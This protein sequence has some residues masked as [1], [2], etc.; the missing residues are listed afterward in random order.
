M[1]NDELLDL[2]NEK[3]EVIG[4]VLRS[5]AM[6]DPAK[7]YRIVSVTIF[8]E[9]DEVLIQKRGINKSHPGKWENSASGHVLAGETPKDAAQ[10]GLFEELGIKLDLKYYDKW[11]IPGETK[12]KFMWMFCAVA[13]KSVEFKLDNR[14]VEEIL[15]I[16]PSELT[17]FALNNFWDL[18]GYSQKEIMETKKFLNI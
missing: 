10:R 8:N 13:P 11:F 4:T 3:D 16:K 17:R 15:W 1:K 9:N 2:V 18:N 14:E 6:I 5:V 7:I 12:N